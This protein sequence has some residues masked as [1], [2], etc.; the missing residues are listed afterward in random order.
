MQEFISVVETFSPLTEESRDLLRMAGKRAEL[1]K[2]DFLV[3]PDTHCRYFYFVES[4]L[5]RTFYYKDGKDITDWFSWE[6]TFAVSIISFLTGNPDRRGIEALE[7]TTILAFSREDLERICA[8]RHDV[9][10][11]V[12]HLV[13]FSAIQLQQKIDDAH[14]T[15]ASERYTKLVEAHSGL[16]QRV[17]LGMVASYIGVTQETL[18]RIRAHG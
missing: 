7:P 17:P 11:L 3:K 10:R 16:L 9:E 13:S 8:E 1:R 14:F 15:T 6:G 18:S 4:G 2:G 5:T 12:R